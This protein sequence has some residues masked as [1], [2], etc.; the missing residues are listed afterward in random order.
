MENQ[1][2]LLLFNR[3]RH[4]VDGCGFSGNYTDCGLYRRENLADFHRRNAGLI[5]GLMQVLGIS[6]GHSDEESARGL[7]VE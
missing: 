2:A 4:E 6:T 7:W 5:Q 1:E 3:C